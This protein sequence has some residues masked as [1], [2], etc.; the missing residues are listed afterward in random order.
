MK[1]WILSLL[2]SIGLMNTASAAAAFDEAFPAENVVQAFNCVVQKNGRLSKHACD[3]AE[4]ARCNH[5]PCVLFFH[6]SKEPDARIGAE[7]IHKLRE[8]HPDL[9]EAASDIAVEL[10]G[11]AAE[12]GRS[13]H[14]GWR[15]V[16]AD[17]VEQFWLGVAPGVDA[18]ARSL[19]DISFSG[20]HL[21]PYILK[22]TYNTAA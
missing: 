18:A 22:I 11:I 9:P 14:S 7:L 12:A 13:I 20:V 4:A 21:A 17:E 3:C 19:K 15:R 16:T 5:L 1:K 8:F 6:L 10:Y 2:L